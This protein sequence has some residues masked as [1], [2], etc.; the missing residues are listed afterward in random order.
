MSYYPLHPNPVCHHSLPLSASHPLPLSVII[1]SLCLSSSSPFVCH[2]HLPLS[3]TIPSFCLS[4]SSLF[5]YQ[6]SS[7][8]NIFLCL[9][10]S[11][12]FVIIISLCLSS[13]SPFV[14][15]HHLPFSTNQLLPLNTVYHHHLP[16]SSTALFVSHH[17][18]PLSVIIISLCLST[19]LSLSLSIIISPYLTSSSPLIS[20]SYASPSPFVSH[21]HLPV[22]VSH[23][24]PL[25]VDPT[26]SPIVWN[27][28]PLPGDHPNPFTRTRPSIWTSPTTTTRAT[29]HR[30]SSSAA[31]GAATRCGGS[32][33]R[34]GIRRR[35]RCRRFPVFHNQGDTAS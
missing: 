16:L 27:R 3:V 15:H 6:P 21:H 2:H 8:I 12:L 33:S 23:P 22:S 24:L 32:S 28:T 14:C 30:I 4:S 5:V 26:P 9:L 7:V 13:S 11:S 29:R 17:Q 10:S 34:R 35:G 31:D 25:S 1:I 20:S 19:I 18:L